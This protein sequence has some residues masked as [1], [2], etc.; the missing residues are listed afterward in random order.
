[1]AVLVVV[2]AVA[3]PAITA[4]IRKSGSYHHEALY[5]LDKIKGGARQYYVTDHWDSNGNLLAKGFPGGVTRTP[6]KPGCEWIT[7]PT[8][9]WDTNGW[10]PLNFAPF[11][12]VCA[13]EFT[14]A[15]IATSASYTARALCDYD[16]D[17]TWATYEIRGSVDAEGSVKVQ[18]PMVT[19]ERE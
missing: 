13:Y 8:S 3:V 10:A 11:R 1:M 7:T 14:S 2:L 17:G 12:H 9:T 16:C 19:N 4:Y 15:G 5:V 6:A 18:G